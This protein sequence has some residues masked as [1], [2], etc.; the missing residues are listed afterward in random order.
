MRATNCCS[1]GTQFPKEIFWYANSR[2][3]KLQLL[4]CGCRL[5]PLIASLC[6][7]SFNLDGEWEMAHSK[8]IGKN[9]LFPAKIYF[10]KICEYSSSL[11]KFQSQPWLLISVSV[12]FRHTVLPMCFWCPMVYSASP[13]KLKYMGHSHVSLSSYRGADWFLN[14]NI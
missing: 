10:R 5:L 12:S 7:N 2:W 13:I 11:V 9:F 8:G 1:T 14:K 6:K 4:S 3:Q